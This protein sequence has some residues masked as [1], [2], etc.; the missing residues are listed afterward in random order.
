MNFREI[1]PFH[2][3]PNY[4]NVIEDT[5][6][7]VRLSDNPD[8]ATFIQ[9]SNIQP[10][11][12]VFYYDHSSTMRVHAAVVTESTFDKRQNMFN[13][14]FLYMLICFWLLSACTGGKDLPLV[15]TGIPAPSPSATS[16]PLP[17]AVATLTPSPVPSSQPADS[18]TPTPTP[19]VFHGSDDCGEQNERGHILYLSKNSHSEENTAWASRYDL[20]IMNGNGCYSSLALERVSGSPAWSKDGKFIAIGCENNTHL[21]ILDGQA[22][23]DLCLNAQDLNS[24]CLSAALVKN[25]FVLPERSSGNVNDFYNITWSHDGSKI[26]IESMEASR[27]CPSYLLDLASGTWLPLFDGYGPYMFDWSP[28]TSYLASSGVYFVDID[29]ASSERISE[30]LPLPLEPHDY[31]QQLFD[32][33]ISPAW[34]PDGQ[35]IAFIRPSRDKNQE[36]TGIGQIN[37]VTHELTWLYEPAN[38]DLHY[39]LPQNLFIGAD[40]NHRRMLSWSPDGQFIVF[41]SPFKNMFYNHIFR[42]NIATGEILILTDNHKSQS[43]EFYGPAWGP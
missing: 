37:L 8:W 18:P 7:F 34:S 26:V 15:E 17:V 42:L 19:R 4:D 29:K 28:V 36:P 43:N 1:P 22:V 10:G 16:S 27:L 23:I 24:P 35:K 2:N 11:D 13:Q 3:V 5:W 30:T 6:D 38:R 33:G 40:S 14:R 25:K 20:Y 31:G 39:W 41:T 12:I 21:C 32:G 9:N